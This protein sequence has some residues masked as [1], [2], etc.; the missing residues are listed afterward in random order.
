MLPA[1]SRASEHTDRK[2]SD[3]VE[4]HV[5][6]IDHQMPLPSSSSEK[7]LV[8]PKH[9]DKPV[10]AS[11][12]RRY[13]IDKSASV[14]SLSHS[15]DSPH[16]RISSP[17]V[18]FH[19][20]MSTLQASSAKNLEN[21]S[22]SGAMGEGAD[23]EDKKLREN[24]K[25]RSKNWTR[26]ESLQLIRL[27]TQLEPRFSKS[28]R[29]TELWDEIAEALHKKN[30]TR[31]AQQCRDKWEKLT[32]GYK[33]VRD[34]IKDKEDN[35]FYDELHSLLS[36]K[37]M[38]RDREKERDDL[39]VQEPPK[40]STQDTVTVIEQDKVES[41]PKTS[42]THEEDHDEAAGDESARKKRRPE[43]KFVT[44]TDIESVQR[45]LETVIT[46]QQ[47]FFRELLDAMERKEQMREQMRQE[48]EDKWRAE[49]RA[50]RGVFNN[51]MIVLTQK[52]VGEQMGASLAMAS[53]ATAAPQTEIPP[54]LPPAVNSPEG[55]LGVPKRRSKNWKRTE[56]LQFIKLRGEMD[57]RFAHSTRRAALWDGLAERLLVQGIKRDGKQCREKWDKLMAEYKDV[58]DGKRDQRESPYYSE[59]TAILGRPVEAP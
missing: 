52:L 28:G 36:G 11:P 46:R 37:S 25:K 56:V 30:F 26:P 39:P 34:G 50:H 21:G 47:I 1:S 18:A 59:L 48:K 42:E 3:V 44:V 40:S 53:T 58:T 41:L 2:A 45:V 12:G 24:H 51:A 16:S 57:S 7:Q 9:K 33:E 22:N 14:V 13:I 55:P 38:K 27:R 29:K 15:L 17:L 54:P 5:F 43:P 35:P 32:A 10:T 20:S 19:Q 23:E 8:A 4:P 6:S 31:D 49:E